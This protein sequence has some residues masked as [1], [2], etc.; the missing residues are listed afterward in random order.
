[1]SRLLGLA[2]IV[3]ATS[4][5]VASAAVSGGSLRTAERFVARHCHHGSVRSKNMWETDR[6]FH[7]NALY[8]DCGGGD[9]HDQRI[10]FFDGA[11]FIG[12]DTRGSSAGIIGLWRDLNTI[13]FMYVLYRPSDALCCATG[14]GTVVRYRW[15]GKH[16]VRL[17]PL[18]HRTASAH[19]PGRYP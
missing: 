3:A 6:T 19:H 18:P 11:R 7:F 2:V 10:W 14:G 1:M 4:A 9:G 15:T 13:T 5:A 8:G 16:V 17:D 12:A